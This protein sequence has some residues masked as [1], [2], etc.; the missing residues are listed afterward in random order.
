MGLPVSLGSLS[1]RG[2][3]EIAGTGFAHL[4]GIHALDMQHYGGI[5][6]TK[7]FDLRGNNVLKI[8]GMLQDLVRGPCALFLCGAR[9]MKSARCIKTK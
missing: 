3:C 5:N 1:L 7:L 6:V 8:R 4:T 2:C 9:T